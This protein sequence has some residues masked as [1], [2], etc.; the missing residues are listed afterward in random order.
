MH[1]DLGE[2]ETF[3]NTSKIRMEVERKRK[4]NKNINRNISLVFSFFISS[5]KETSLVATC[6]ILELATVGQKIN[7]GNRADK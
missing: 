7:P 5:S 4:R 2:T 6:S 1:S 3:G